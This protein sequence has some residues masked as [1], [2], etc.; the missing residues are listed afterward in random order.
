M[1]KQVNHI[2]NL[3]NVTR[4]VKKPLTRITHAININI[5]NKGSDDDGGGGKPNN[6][7]SGNVNI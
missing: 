7:P 1:S 3:N 6:G 5:N 2:K 4:N